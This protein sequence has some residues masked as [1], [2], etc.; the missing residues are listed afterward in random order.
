MGPKYKI[1]L[2]S[3]QSKSIL[4]CFQ[5]FC[6]HKQYH[7]FISKFTPNMLFVV[8]IN[9]SIMRLAP[10]TWGAVGR[11]RGATNNPFPDCK[12]PVRARVRPATCPRAR[13]VT[14]ICNAID[15][16]QEHFCLRLISHS[17]EMQ[18]PLRTARR[19]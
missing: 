12:P 14:H 6:I 9:Y 18:F 3:P 1:K 7:I 17:E 13:R 5:C 19:R 4:I 11:A 15:P 2:K 8:V 10:D 16:R